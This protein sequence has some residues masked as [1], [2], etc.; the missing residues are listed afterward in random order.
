MSSITLT[1]CPNCNAKVVVQRP[2]GEIV[3][4]QRAIVIRVGCVFA[5]C[6]GCKN[7]THV[8]A[9]SYGSECVIVESEES[10][11]KD[12]TKIEGE[13]TISSVGLGLEPSPKTF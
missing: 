11:E 1:R 7:E 12:L 10:Q 2:N 5:V 13:S 8:E 3:V 9:L 4:L 6:T